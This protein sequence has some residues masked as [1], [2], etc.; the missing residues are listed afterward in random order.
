MTDLNNLITDAGMGTSVAAACQKLS[1]VLQEC[2]TLQ[3]GRTEVSLKTVKALLGKLET[4]PPAPKAVW[5]LVQQLKVG[6]VVG[7]GRIH[8]QTTHA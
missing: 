6:C 7:F 8:Q 4:L 2:S 1:K 5:K 3:P